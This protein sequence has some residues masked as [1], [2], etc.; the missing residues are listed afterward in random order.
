MISKDNFVLLS[1]DTP[2][3][4]E[5]LII[6]PNPTS[7]NIEI[8]KP[9]ALKITNIELFNI[10]GQLVSSYNYSR[11]IQLGEL[12]KGQYFFKF[13]SDSGIIYKALII[14]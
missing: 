8:N 12:S 7:S 14:N 6:Y 1:S 10:N 9:Y 2:I 4:N 5:K 3:I 11:N 13:Y